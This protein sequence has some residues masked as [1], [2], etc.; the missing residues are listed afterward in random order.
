MSTEAFDSKTFLQALNP[1]CWTSLHL[2]AFFLYFQKIDISLRDWFGSH[3]MYTAQQG[4]KVEGG[5]SWIP[6]MIAN[7]WEIWKKIAELV[8]S[9]SLKLKECM[10]LCICMSVAFTHLCVCVLY[11]SVNVWCLCSCVVDGMALVCVEWDMEHVCVYVWMWVRCSY[12]RVLVSF[13]STQH[14]QESFGKRESQLKTHLLKSAYRQV[15]S[16]FSWLTIDL[17]GSSS[18]G[19]AYLSSCFWKT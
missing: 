17:D 12:L 7:W 11:V 9:L 16:A 10:C 14:K 13:I 15:C 1:T 3:L 18:W 8:H 5:F 6:E 4:F 2:W 19:G